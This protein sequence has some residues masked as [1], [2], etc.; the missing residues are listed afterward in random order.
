[1]MVIVDVPAPGDAMGLG[2]KVERGADKVIADLKP[3]PT[4]VV[5]VAVPELPWATVRVLGET[6]MMK[7]AVTVRET[8]VVSVMLPLVPVM[9]MV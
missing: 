7:L 4:F 6:A 8:V 1:M 5:T 3:F 9:V 2:L